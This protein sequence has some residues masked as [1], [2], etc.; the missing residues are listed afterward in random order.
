[1]QLQ[2]TSYSVLRTLI[3]PAGWTLACG[4]SAA[5]TGSRKKIFSDTHAVLDGGNSFTQGQ[6]LLQTHVRAYLFITSTTA[7]VAQ[8]RHLQQRWR[9][10]LSSYGHS[11]LREPHR[12]HARWKTD[13]ART[14]VQGGYALTGG[15]FEVHS[16]VV[17]AY[18]VTFQ[19]PGPSGR[20]CLA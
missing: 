10:D 20:A 1:M 5:L 12:A 11:G 16:G 4:A 14:E 15:V 13:S 2:A 9:S 7:Y 19:C 3:V 17:E 6:G 18:S 8:P